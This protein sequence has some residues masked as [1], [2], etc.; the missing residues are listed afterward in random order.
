MIDVDRKTPDGESVVAVVGT[1]EGRE[2]HVDA[3]TGYIQEL[4][5]RWMATNSY[6]HHVRRSASL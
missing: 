5:K 2:T 3:T 1:I 4:I 6:D